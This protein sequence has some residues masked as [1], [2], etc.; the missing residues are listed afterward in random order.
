MDDYDFHNLHN[1]WNTYIQKY[2][3]KNYS[4]VYNSP[5]H[6]IKYVKRLF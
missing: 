2:D 4:S 6:D 1:L 3:L 5:H